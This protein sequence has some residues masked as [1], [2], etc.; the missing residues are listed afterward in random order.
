MKLPPTF[1][2][3]ER[4]SGFKQVEEALGDGI[5]MA[6][7]SST[8]N[9]LSRVLLTITEGLPPYLSGRRL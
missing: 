3:R 9:C 7:P 2:Q 5:V 8:S 6:V 1:I 4:D